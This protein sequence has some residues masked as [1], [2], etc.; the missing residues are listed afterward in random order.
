MNAIL[1]CLINIDIF[2]AELMSNFKNFQRLNLASFKTN[3]SK[4]E[5]SGSINL[6]DEIINLEENTDAKNKETLYL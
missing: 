5:Y 2:Y 4:S 6:E 3:F 1:Q